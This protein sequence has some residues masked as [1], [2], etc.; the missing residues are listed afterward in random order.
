MSKT[1]TANI[2]PVIIEAVF[3]VCITLYFFCACTYGLKYKLPDEDE[4]SYGIE[5]VQVM[6]NIKPS[7]GLPLFGRS[8]PV[9]D[10][11]NYNFTL[12]A[13]LLLP[14]FAVFGVSTWSLKMMPICISVI[15]IITAYYLIKNIFSAKIAAVSAALL[16]TNPV[17]I[18]YSINCLAKTEPLIN[19][20]FLAAV[21][22]F[23]L[24][25][26]KRDLYLISLSFLFLG[27][28]ASVK[29]S[30]FSYYIGLTAASVLVYRKNI[31]EL[32]HDRG[33][34]TAAVI[35]FMAG[36]SIFISYNI[37]F[38][39]DSTF[40][41]FR[42]LYDSSSPMCQ[43]LQHNLKILTNLG[44]R[45]N[46]LLCLW[47]NDEKQYM[48]DIK[49]GL[50]GTLLF[51]LTLVS[52]IVNYL[53]YASMEV[54]DDLKKYIFICVLFIV[55]FLTSIITPLTRDEFHLVLLFPFQQLMIGIFL[56]NTV[57]FINKAGYSLVV[58]LLPWIIF[59]LV[60][61]FQVNNTV[62]YQALFKSEFQNGAAADEYLGKLLGWVNKSDI[63]VVILDHS[64]EQ[65][66]VMLSRGRFTPACTV[67]WWS[68]N[69]TVEAL[70]NTFNKYGKLYLVECSEHSIIH[71]NEF[72]VDDVLWNKNLKK[73]LIQSISA[74]KYNHVYFNIY[75]IYES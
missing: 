62:R 45:G 31:K 70:I 34:I 17:Y 29:L 9:R 15:G 10:I 73:E 5:A 16:A 40:N 43:Y 4:I 52:V 41:N 60:L 3:L 37:F 66:L 46:H 65:S 57:S 11:M 75:K 61:C 28:G 30:A 2:N 42:F 35:S 8:L 20:L 71:H 21:L 72:K 39:Y 47:S 69:K 74:G 27:A 54:K 33:S 56:V 19:T 6:E 68:L 13:Y 49:N 1:I 58:K 22:L 67:Y 51:L 59:S 26:K 38:Q 64:N 53:Y 7:F 36:A 14:F 23:V 55:V 25:V 32:F 48:P 63:P 18:L 50:G 24:Y 12:P 44:I